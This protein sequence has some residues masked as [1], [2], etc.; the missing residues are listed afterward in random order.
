MVVGTIQK[1][2]ENVG[3]AGEE[4]YLSCTLVHGICLFIFYS[5]LLRQIL[6]K[7]NFFGLPIIMLCQ[8]LVSC[9]MQMKSRC[10]AN[11]VH[12]HVSLSC[13]IFQIII[14]YS[15]SSIS[16]IDTENNSSF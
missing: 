16:V 8:F 11:K 12:E 15:K 1:R 6:T 10:I 5:N 3:L 2:I 7:A 14:F 9:H 13:E 4:I